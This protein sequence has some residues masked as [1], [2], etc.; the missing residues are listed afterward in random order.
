MPV[1]AS[2]FKLALIWG[3]VI[4]LS[5]FI[6]SEL[7]IALGHASMARA[8]VWPSSLVQALVPTP[9]LGTPERP[10]YEG[11]PPHLL[12]WYVGAALTFPLYVGAIYA[13][14]VLRRKHRAL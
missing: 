6:A 12:A 2:P 10:I 4:A 5:L 11:T 8:L 9:N 13:V 3:G 1:Q 7:A 14:L